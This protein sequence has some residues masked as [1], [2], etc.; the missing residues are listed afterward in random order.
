MLW[1]TIFCLSSAGSK[2]VL[3]NFQGLAYMHAFLGQHDRARAIFEQGRLINP[4][5]SRF[6][7]AFAL[8]EKRQGRLQVGSWK[9]PRPLLSA[10][11]Q[12]LLV[13]GAARCLQG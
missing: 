5:T 12:F 9:P 10:W 6:L 4:Q 13:C 2:A 3:Q 1:S 7:R 11:H 8:F